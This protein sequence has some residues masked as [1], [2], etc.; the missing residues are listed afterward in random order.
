[1]CFGDLVFFRSLLESEA[2]FVLASVQRGISRFV[3]CGLYETNCFLSSATE[4]FLVLRPLDI[5]PFFSNVC[6]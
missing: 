5:S 2:C 1:M 4:V 6:G 3:I